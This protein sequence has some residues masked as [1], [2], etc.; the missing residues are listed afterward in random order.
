MVWLEE[1]FFDIF[2]VSER[3]LQVDTNPANKRQ[4]K[5]I[6]DWKHLVSVPLE[7]VGDM[8]LRVNRISL[9][10]IYH[11]VLC[12]KPVGPRY[13]P[14]ES[15]ARPWRAFVQL[16][17]VSAPRDHNRMVSFVLMVWIAAPIISSAVRPNQLQQNGPLTIFARLG[18]ALSG[19]EWYV[20][21][22]PS[23]ISMMSQLFIAYRSQNSLWRRKR[24]FRR[25]RSCSFL[26]RLKEVAIGS[27]SLWSTIGSDSNV[28]MLGDFRCHRMSV[29]A[30]T[31]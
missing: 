27:R 21:I 2:S 1:K 20:N 22:C 25:F 14:D 24:L 19:C 31:F 18:G 13:C 8:H 28:L 11:S 6:K 9:H 29:C 23:G 12:T 16:A 10:S 4:L 30:W 3:T 7:H 17:A 5:F 26:T 15:A